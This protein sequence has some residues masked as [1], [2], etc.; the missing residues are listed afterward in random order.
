MIIFWIFT[1]FVGASAFSFAYIFMQLDIGWSIAYAII[2]MLFARG[3][4]SIIRRWLILRESITPETDVLKRTVEVNRAIFWRRS[5]LRNS[6]TR[7]PRPR[8]AWLRQRHRAGKPKQTGNW[9]G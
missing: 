7:S 1:L 3:I 4:L 2:A 6:T 9:P 5:P 8:P